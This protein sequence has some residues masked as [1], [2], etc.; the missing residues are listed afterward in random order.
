MF[1]GCLWSYCLRWCIAGNITHLPPHGSLSRS[2][3]QLPLSPFVFEW[4]AWVLWGQIM[5]QGCLTV[6]QPS[7]LP[8]KMTLGLVRK[9]VLMS[10]TILMFRLTSNL[11]S[12]KPV[13]CLLC[14]ECV[15]WI[16]HRSCYPETDSERKSG[17]PRVYLESA[18]VKREGTEA[19]QDRGKSGTKP[20]STPGPWALEGDSLLGLKWV[21]LSTLPS[22][23]HQMCPRPK[24]G[25]WVLCSRQ[26][27][28]ADPT[29]H[30]WAAS[31]SMKG[32]QRAPLWDFW[33]RRKL[34]PRS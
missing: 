33:L 23:S 20:P 7:V 16:C 17:V 25:E 15:K 14:P 24:K 30:R 8:P 1:N 5:Q 34:R 2:L 6:L 31:C 12:S 21:G 32:K 18:P 11:V 3:L 27:E 9:Y 10:W 28:A 26:L 4:F 29:S 19:A 22:L 13:A